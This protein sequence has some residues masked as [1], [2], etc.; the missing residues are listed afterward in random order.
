MFNCGNRNTSFIEKK[1]FTTKFV[2]GQTTL[3]RVPY[4]FWHFFFILY[5]LFHLPPCS[6]LKDKMFNGKQVRS[7]MLFLELYL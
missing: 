7:F 1:M 3:K 2:F 6:N 4:H 5:A